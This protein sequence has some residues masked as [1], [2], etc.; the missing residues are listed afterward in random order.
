V[1]APEGS[2]GARRATHSWAKEGKTKISGGLDILMHAFVAGKNA[3]DMRC[4]ASRIHNCDAAGLLAVKRS[5]LWEKRTTLEK[6]PSRAEGIAGSARRTGKATSSQIRSMAGGIKSERAAIKRAQK[7]LAKT[8]RDLSHAYRTV[9]F[10]FEAAC[11]LV[12]PSG[13]A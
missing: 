10:R 5:M 11:R 4:T 3:P 6:P 13:K 9:S 12:V 2:P 7:T 1:P 8:G